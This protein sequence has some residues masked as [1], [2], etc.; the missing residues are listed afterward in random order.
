MMEP[1][2][3]NLQRKCVQSRSADTVRLNVFQLGERHA[4]RDT[5]DALS[6]HLDVLHSRLH[7]RRSAPKQRKK[8]TEQCRSPTLPGYEI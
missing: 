3:Y 1:G 7:W 8:S 2:T 5:P 4:L 6:T